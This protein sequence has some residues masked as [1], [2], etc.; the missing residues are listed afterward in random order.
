MLK[1]ALKEGVVGT[2]AHIEIGYTNP[3]DFTT[4]KYRRVDDRPFG[5]GDSMVMM[6]QV[7]SQTI[8]AA[9]ENLPKAR[10]IYLSPQGQNFSQSKACELAKCE[11]IILLS[12]RYAG[13]DQRILNTLVD[14]EISIGDYV[15]SGGELAALV[16]IDVVG[17]LVPGVLGNKE[18][19]QN[20]SF[21]N[22]LLEAPLFT[23][24]R[25]FDDQSVPEILLSG[26]HKKIADFQKAMG[27]F[28]TFIKRPDLLTKLSEEELKNLGASQKQLK[29]FLDLWNPSSRSH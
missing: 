6:P 24:P 1:A 29:L 8:A 19:A 16:V 4:D 28:T 10:V 26:D 2:S 23:R 22:G 13:V 14:E 18:S 17:R 25:I 12:G 3:R 20:D 11:E 5:G 15:L 21:Q 9:K 7:L 27:L